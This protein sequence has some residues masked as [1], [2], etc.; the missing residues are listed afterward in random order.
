M[1]NHVEA[2]ARRRLNSEMVGEGKAYREPWSETVE[3]PGQFNVQKLKALARKYGGDLPAIIE[4]AKVPGRRRL[5][6]RAKEGTG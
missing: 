4:A 6:V 1:P 2:S 3:H 5:V